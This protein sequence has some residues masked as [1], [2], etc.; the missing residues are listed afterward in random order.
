[1]AQN[2][3]LVGS[4]HIIGARDFFSGQWRLRRLFG[5]WIKEKDIA[6]EDIPST[7][8]LKQITK[9]GKPPAYQPI[10]LIFLI[11]GAIVF[12]A[13]FILIG[14]IVSRYI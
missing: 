14:V 1:V 6:Q 2:Q 7:E 12:V 8:A 9:E 13:F 4:S 11:L 3:G 5:K 10:R